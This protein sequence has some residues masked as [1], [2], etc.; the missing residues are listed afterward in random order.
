M[1]DFG[2]DLIQSMSEALAHARG[3]N[4]GV[5]EHHVDIGTVDPKQVRARLSLTQEQMAKFLGASLSG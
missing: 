4:V 1:T 2:K 3:E 5:I